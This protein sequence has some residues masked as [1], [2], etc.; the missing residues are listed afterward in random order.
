MSTSSEAEEPPRRRRQHVPIHWHQTDLTAGTSAV[1]PAAAGRDRVFT[2][3][4]ALAVN[5]SMFDVGRSSQRPWC[6]L[7]TRCRALDRCASSCLLPAAAGGRDT[8]L[9]CLSLCVNNSYSG[10]FAA[11]QL[12]RSVSKNG[13]A[14]PV[15]GHHIWK[16]N[17][18]TQTTEQPINGLHLLFYFFSFPFQMSV[19]FV[20][21]SAS[22]LD[23]SKNLPELDFCS[24]HTLLITPLCRLKA[25]KFTNTVAFQSRTKRMPFERALQLRQL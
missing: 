20:T 9:H 25:V 1:T 8:R 3:G 24:P 19:F 15:C 21:F 22:C 16:W 12:I 14:A 6:C 2:A 7:L 13:A 4:L 18:R 10:C 5:V 11:A 17:C 23:Y